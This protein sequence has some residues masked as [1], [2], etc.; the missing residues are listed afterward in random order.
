MYLEDMRL[1]YSVLYKNLN[2]LQNLQKPEEGTF[3][4]SQ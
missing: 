4:N 2:S 1:L 3:V